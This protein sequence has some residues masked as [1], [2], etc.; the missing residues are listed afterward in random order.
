M[1][2][3]MLSKDQ[4]RKWLLTLIGLIALI[5]CY[6]AFLLGPLSRTQAQMKS[7]TAGYQAKLGQARELLNAVKYL[8]KTAP[9]TVAMIKTFFSDEK[10]DVVSVRLVGA[11]PFKKPEFAAF[12]MTDW[13]VEMSH[14][15]FWTLG[16]KIARL[17]NEWPL[18]HIGSVRIKTVPEEPADQLVTLGLFR[19]V[20]Q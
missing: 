8:E 10:I 17:E 7:A 16:E 5:Y 6:N 19:I 1:H 3:Q 9:E 11:R 2:S 20:K 4:I 13:A 14:V 12:A 18:S 15:D